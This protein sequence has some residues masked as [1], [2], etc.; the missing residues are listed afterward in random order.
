MIK[1]KSK[2]FLFNLLII[3]LFV[4]YTFLNFSKLDIKELQGDEASSLIAVIPAM[5]ANQNFRFLGSIFL[6]GH[7]PLRGLVEIPFLYFFGLKEFWLYLPNVT[8]SLGIFLINFLIMK[9]WFKRKTALI[10]S[11]FLAINGGIILQRMIMGVGL[12]IFF[13]LL[14]L[15]FFLSFLDTKKV[16][17]YKKTLVFLFLAV[18]TYEE[19]II[20]I[21]VIFYWLIKKRLWRQKKVTKYSIYFIISLLIFFGLWFLIP[22]I[23]YHLGY[24]SNLFDLGAF[25]IIKRS[26]GGFNLN[27]SYIYVLLHH[28]NNLALTWIIIFGLGFS[29]WAKEANFFWS[30]LILPLIY[31]SIIKDPTVHLYNYLSLI[32]IIS[33][34]GW[35]QL[36]KL[37]IFQKY[38]LFLYFVLIII[39]ITNIFF[40]E[41]NYYLSKSYFIE[42]DWGPVFN[43]GLKAKAYEIREMTNI[44]DLIYTDIEGSSARLYFGRR[45]TENPAE[46]KIIVLAKDIKK[47][48]NQT[49]LFNKKYSSFKNLMPYLTCYD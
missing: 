38:E 15:Y 33:S 14:M 47:D 23:A 32:I 42:G 1:I 12:F 6:F 49:L 9:K 25:R 7:V 37:K 48:N 40:L 31:F 35:K 39:A 45:Y 10:G 20:A 11:V 36:F 34:I 28:Y 13:N 29:F 21:P 2:N 41:K 18:L 30:F 3:L 5:K 19:G 4:V 43:I 22:W 26:V 17:Q 24:V 8:A 16:S 46:A 44:C 27:I